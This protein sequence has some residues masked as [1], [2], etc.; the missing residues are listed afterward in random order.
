[1]VVSPA[2]S[3]AVPTE[4]S[5]PNTSGKPWTAALLDAELLDDFFGKILLH[6]FALE[7]TT[8]LASLNRRHASSLSAI[9]R[10]DSSKELILALA[11]LIFLIA[12]RGQT[13]GVHLLGL[14]RVNR[15]KASPQHRNSRD[16]DGD[17]S[18]VRLGVFAAVKII[19]P[20]VY[21]MCKKYW[22]DQRPQRLQRMMEARV[23]PPEAAVNDPDDARR[24]ED[25]LPS[26]ETFSTSTTTT[27][28]DSLQLL[29]WER[30][31]KAAAFVIKLVDKLL[32]SCQLA[33]LLFCWSGKSFTP[34]AAMIASGLKY[35]QQQQST[36]SNAGH[37]PQLTVAYA[38]RRWMYQQ[39]L[40]TVRIL[41]LGWTMT[42]IWQPV[43]A[44][45][46]QRWRPQVVSGV[47]RVQQWLQK[48]SLWHK[49]A[50]VD[51]SHAASKHSSPESE[52]QCLLC[53]A[54]PI[55]IPVLT[56]CRCHG[57]YCYTCLYNYQYTQSQSSC[58][59][60]RAT[61]RCLKCKD[62]VTQASFS[63]NKMLTR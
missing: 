18:T 1:M 44:A 50:A 53:R 60:T 7:I 63:N 27:S 43:V 61:I 52:L 12:S 49:V 19:L 11:K 13:P 6:S 2:V 32:P 33:A 15:N 10:K 47:D 41:M 21:S 57:A 45:P 9:L 58:N 28:N 34:C 29:A 14:K 42:S 48:T 54:Q 30:Q 37:Q 17:P 23:W 26:V 8:S 40:Q 39:L 62:I 55:V 51:S 5:S 4:S 3:S 38:H 36:R 20:T 24:N 16:D 59:S 31:E 25:R 46:W 22:N 35:V 56:N